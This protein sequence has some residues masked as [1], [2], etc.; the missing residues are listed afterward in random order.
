[1]ILA[2]SV[3]F[4]EFLSALK[5]KVSV[6]FHGLEVSMRETELLVFVAGFHTPFVVLSVHNV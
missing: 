1:M 4:S 5:L 2:S 3:G 6:F